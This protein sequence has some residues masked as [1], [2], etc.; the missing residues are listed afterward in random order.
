MQIGDVIDDP[1]GLNAA[2]RFFFCNVQIETED[3]KKVFCN[4]VCVF[5]KN[6]K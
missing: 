1:K 6:K 4:F 2:S 5:K 3:F